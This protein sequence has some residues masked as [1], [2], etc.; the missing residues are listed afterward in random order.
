MNEQK[1]K[2]C[3]VAAVA[4]CLIAVV[5]GVAYKYFVHPHLAGKLKEATGSSS[6]YKGEVR[7]G[8]DS[9]SGYCIFRS[10]ALKQ[11]LKSHGL[12]LTVQDDKADGD[13]RL[14]SLRD[15]KTQFAVFTIDSLLA[16]GA[17]AGDFPA[18]IIW[19]I[20]ETKGGDA[21]VSYQSGVASLQD[22][23]TASARIVLTPNSPSE[24]LARVVLANFY[25]PNLREPWKVGAD[26]AGAV[27][28]AF[29]ATSPTEKKAFVLW[30]PYVSKALELPGAH[31][32][33]DS[34]K[35]KGLIVDVLVVQRQFLRDEPEVVKAVVEG[36]A[37]S[38]YA[39]GQQQDGMFKLVARDAQNSGSESLNETQARKVVEGIQWKNTLENYAHFNL[40]S[41]ADQGGLQ[42][43]EDMIG[44][45]VEV[46]VK[47]KAL[48]A[49]PLSG[50]YAMRSIT[51]R[52]S[53]S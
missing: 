53:A 44:R 30:E 11:E 33:I 24:F 26:G 16:A 25:L 42:N 37:R 48:T 2:G 5:L 17:K 41:G 12:K 31:L 23:N 7:V 10:D 39:Y 15:G 19:V 36:Y 46:L 50:N 21:M 6:H 3:L 34:S 35:L 9:F 20:D 52:F 29:R 38:A 13:A 1:S 27:F 43:L 18:T 4:W 40:V 32:L 49:D 8:A 47:T 22:L 51:I 28:K 14:Q 45:I